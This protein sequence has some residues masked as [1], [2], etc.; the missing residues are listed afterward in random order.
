MSSF[1]SN[2]LLWQNLSTL[3]ELLT[4]T[5]L[6]LFTFSLKL[7]CFPPW[8]CWCLIFRR[9]LRWRHLRP[10][11]IQ[12]V[13]PGEVSSFHRRMFCCYFS[14]VDLTHFNFLLA[15]FELQHSL[16]WLNRSY[17]T[18]SFVASPCCYLWLWSRSSHNQLK[19]DTLCADFLV[20]KPQNEEILILLC[21]MDFV[22]QF[23]QIEIY[24]R[25]LRPEPHNCWRPQER[26]PTLDVVASTIYMSYPPFCHYPSS[27]PFWH[28]RKMVLH[29]Q[30]SLQMVLE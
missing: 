16:L 15:R 10:C 30:D 14:S 1:H 12:K 29:H 3:L 28:G 19:I 22:H 25:S 5:V 21:A 13:A 8:N 4:F 17:L 9:I 11:S 26:S 20:V 27:D 23:R 18:P 7:D 24:S 6:L 2:I